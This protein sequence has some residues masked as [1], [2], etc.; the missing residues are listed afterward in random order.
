MENKYRVLGICTDQN[1]KNG[2][3][4]YRTGDNYGAVGWYRIVN[5]LRK[6]GA[7]ITVGLTLRGTAEGA[8]ALRERGEI[9]F[10]KMSDNPDIDHIYGAHKDLTGA[11]F[12]LDLDDYPGMVNSDHPDFKAL[13]VRR[14]MRERMIKMADHVVVSTPLIKEAIKDLNSFCTVIPNAI[15]PAIWKFKNQKKN[16]GKIRIGWISSG[17]H[18]SDLPIIED[19][20][21]EIMDKY[22]NVEFHFAGMSW[23]KVARDQFFHHIGVRSYKQFPRWYS[24][25]GFDIAIA[26]LKDTQFNQAKSNIKYLEAAMLE[27]PIVASDVEPYRSIQ[28]GKTGFLASSREHWMKYLIKLIEDKDL[29][30]R[31]GKAAKQDAL[32]NWTID[33]FLPLYEDLLKK[34]LDKKDITVITAITNK[35]D[36]LEP[37]PYYPGVKYLAFL[38]EELKDECWDVKKACDKFVK[39]VMNAKI[40][41]IL[42]HKYC[43]TPYILWMDG[44]CTLKQD[45][46]ELVKL[47]GDKDMLVFKHPG[48]DCIYEEM[49]VC[50]SLNKINL[51][52]ASQ[53]IKEYAKQEWPPH[54]GLFELTCFIRKNTPELN[55]LCEKWWAEI[56]R[57][58]SRDQLSFPIIFQ[59]HKFSF[60]PGNI[61]KI[62]GNKDFPGNKYFKY[63]IHK[64]Y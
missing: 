44:N 1:I 33:K 39:P 4:I 18:F 3:V 54:N 37:Q 64:Y 11:K 36:A 12:V 25:K 23:D 55:T 17:S 41:K 15:D 61:A 38:D 19:V 48:R 28:H 52:E 7:D 9:W 6:L 22:K 27:I 60:I 53:Q 50:A 21:Q 57:F 24:E 2:K 49:D 16:D 45:P 32:D 29:R 34:M 10:S 58:T 63:K 31:I 47:M 20:M 13:E 56:C 26:P 42:A 40:H 43:D 30:E 8:F 51:K 62:E 14:P 5:P 59:G 46:H 35:K